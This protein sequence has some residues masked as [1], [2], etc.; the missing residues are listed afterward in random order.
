MK[1]KFLSS[2]AVL[3]PVLNMTSQSLHKASQSLRSFCKGLLA[4][5]IQ[6]S[7]TPKLCSFR[8]VKNCSGTHFDASD[9]VWFAGFEFH[10]VLMSCHWLSKRPADHGTL[11]STPFLSCLAALLVWGCAWM[12]NKLV[13][14]K[15]I[16]VWKVDN[17]LWDPTNPKYINFQL[18]WSGKMHTIGKLFDWPRLLCCFCR[19]G[20]CISW[21]GALNFKKP[22]NSLRQTSPSF[23][24]RLFVFWLS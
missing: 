18:R 17:W 11:C 9:C 14:N 15:F 22:L 10:M 6:F 16:R 13:T 23:H 2:R 8:P 24:F 20:Q 4:G 3:K 21:T 19:L 5:Q 12:W 7:N 1:C